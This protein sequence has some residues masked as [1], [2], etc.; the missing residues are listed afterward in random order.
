MVTTSLRG[1]LFQVAAIIGAGLLL[2]CASFAANL[3]TGQIN[4]LWANP[5]TNGQYINQQAGPNA[6]TPPNFQFV[7]RNNAATAVTTGVGTDTYTWG[8]CN[9]CNLG[10]GVSPFSRLQWVPVAF[11][12]QA[13][14]VPF[15]LGK[16]IY[17]NGTI[18]L[19]TGTYGGTLQLS[20]NVT[21][22]VNAVAV[23]GVN[24]TFT[25]WDTVNLSTG[26]NGA[27][28]GLTGN[29][30]VNA[31]GKLFDNNG[32]PINDAAG[33]QITLPAG[34]SFYDTFWSADYIS[35][36]ASANANF[37]GNNDAGTF[38]GKSAT[39]DVFGEIVGDPQIQIDYL[40]LDS[41]SEGSGFAIPNSEASDAPE[42]FSI[43]LTAAGLLGLTIFSRRKRS[44]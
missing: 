2:P 6:A 18:N 44:A 24:D 9:G 40:A 12:N 37:S 10:P 23:A 19:G 42:P 29:I 43:A 15:L 25:N 14:N 36:S 22:G 35:F 13:P 20:A 5:V 33:N 7:N 4:G 30:V 21:D 32:N 27:V 3:Y 1:R 11:A 38:E 31:A 39:F 17:T 16:V 34:Q 41:G 8:T 28:T 26:Y